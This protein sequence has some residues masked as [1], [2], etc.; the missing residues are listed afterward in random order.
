M[1]YFIKFLLLK[2][3]LVQ[4][5]VQ[6]KEQHQETVT[7]IAKHDSEQEGEGDKR[8]Q[9]RVYFTVS[10]NTIGINDTLETFSELI[11]TMERWRFLA[12]T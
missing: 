1:S 11:G 8:E 5:E 12:S 6:C 7:S 10:S 4:D 3:L 2:F 9:T